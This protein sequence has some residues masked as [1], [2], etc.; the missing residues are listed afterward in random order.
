MAPPPAPP[1]PTQKSSDAHGRPVLFVVI[2]S[3]SFFII[4]LFL[5]GGLVALKATQRSAAGSE[6]G[7]GKGQTEGHVSESLSDSKVVRDSSEMA[8]NE[9]LGEKDQ[10]ILHMASLLYF[11]V[12]TPSTPCSKITGHL[13]QSL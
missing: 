8:T 4:A 5:S 7:R 3:R 10:P 13:L 1:P 11:K 9:A 6:R 12:L 2:T